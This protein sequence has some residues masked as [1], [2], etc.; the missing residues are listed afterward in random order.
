VLPIDIK[1]RVIF[2]SAGSSFA[3]FRMSLPSLSA[4]R[5]SFVVWFSINPQSQ[6]VE[7]IDGLLAGLCRAVQTR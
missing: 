6:E 7:S 4:E 5:A 3:R 1:D 2:D